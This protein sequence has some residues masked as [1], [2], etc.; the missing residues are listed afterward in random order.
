MIIIFWKILEL[1]LSAITKTYYYF[2]QAENLKSYHL[3]VFIT[4]LGNFDGVH[5]LEI[6]ASGYQSIQTA[7]FPLL[8]TLIK[9]F[10]QALRI[11]YLLSGFLLTQIYS[12]IALILIKKLF[13]LL[14]P[15]HQASLL[16]LLVFP[17]SFFLQT[18]YTEG[19]FLILLVLSFYTLFT[20]KYKSFAIFSYLSSLTRLPGIFLFFPAIFY[21]PK[22]LKLLSLFPILGLGFYC[23]YLFLLNRD[24][25][26]FLHSQ[27][28]FAI[29]RS[30]SPILLPQ[31]LFRY[32]KI[33]LTFNFNLTYFIALFELLIFIFCLLVL[34]L[35]FKKQ[36]QA[37][38]R[39]LISLNI[40]SLANL[41]LPTLTGTLLST[42]RFALLSLSIFIYL[43]N[44]SHKKLK[45]S[46]FFIFFILHL[47]VYRLYLLGLFVS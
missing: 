35:D 16:L 14:S 34:L 38:N 42:P 23:F 30:L 22:K 43:G 31:V 37:Q 4:N 1:L 17:T 28:G 46:L 19:L 21:L 47:L 6:A 29:G 8:P 44:F 32:L 13:K 12:L 41:V 2:P 20:K 15:N 40:F 24:P 11:N 27:T 3:P 36:I 9:N 33:F 45:I 5:Y 7:F 25:L 26:S 10:S 39:K 18:I